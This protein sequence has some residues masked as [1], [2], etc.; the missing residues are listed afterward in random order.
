MDTYESRQVVMA[1]RQ[2]ADQLRIQNQ[3]K[4]LELVDDYAQRWN[5]EDI[6]GMSKKE[7]LKAMKNIGD[8]L[9]K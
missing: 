8:Q 7:W 3:L 9:D 6:D 1:L 4:W 5:F 2:L